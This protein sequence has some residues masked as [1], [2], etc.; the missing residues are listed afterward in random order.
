MVE[1]PKFGFTN[2]VAN[3]L[4][5]ITAEGAVEIFKENSNLDKLI[6]D[7]ACPG[8]TT[9]A[10][11]KVLMKNKPNLISVLNKAILAANKRSK[12]LGKNAKRV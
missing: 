8:V 11:L 6:L 3:D 10:A 7:V 4:V 5:L 2:K 9:E 1:Q 12:K